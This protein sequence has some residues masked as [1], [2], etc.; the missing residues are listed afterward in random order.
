MKKCVPINPFVY[1]KKLS[2]SKE[3]FVIIVSRGL[4]TDIVNIDQLIVSLSI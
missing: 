1:I 3:N 2:M 4:I